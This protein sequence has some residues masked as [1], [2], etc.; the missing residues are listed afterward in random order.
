MFS[1]ACDV[2]GLCSKGMRDGRKKLKE[3]RVVAKKG[4]LMDHVVAESVRPGVKVRADH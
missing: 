3:E 1:V 2:R 4:E